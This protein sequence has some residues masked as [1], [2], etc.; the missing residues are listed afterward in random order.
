M[1]RPRDA[2]WAGAL[3]ILGEVRRTPG[4]T[5]AEAARRLGLGSGSAT[6]ITAR[7]RG[8]DLLDEI[9]AP[10]VG[11]GRP[12]T[13]LRPSPRGPLVAVVE[14]R[15]EDW[16]CAI[17]EIDGRP[18]TVAARRHG[19]GGGEQIV[20]PIAEVLSGLR[21]RYGRRL[22]A[23]SV[24][25]AGAV[26]HGRLVQAAP[27]EW[28]PTDLSGMVPDDAL[29]LLIGNDATLAGLAEARGGAGV[30]AG[31]VLHLTVEVGLGG[32]LVVGGVPVVGAGG[33]GG[34]Y[35]HMPFGDRS[36]RCLC[37]ARGC[38]DNDVD[39]RALARHLGAPPPEDPRAFA[40]EVLQRAA[41]ANAAGQGEGN[42]EADAVRRVA[43]ALASGIA[44]LV[45]AHDPDVVTLGGVAPLIRAAAEEEFDAAYLDGL[46]A[47]RRA[48]PIPLRAVA[49]GD[50]GALIGAAAAGLDLV[51]SESGLNDWAA[52]LEA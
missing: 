37:G 5:R 32:V 38:W 47:F 29:P 28:G 21:S 12:T 41:A 50:E 26:R 15:Y 22:R 17:S 44:G 42:A 39:G 9:P 10:V 40:Y 20:P 24:A 30:R 31:T 6:E 48:D 8:L 19:R 18:V 49:L 27:L 25:V 34:E 3:G 14:V 45:N 43:R 1:A 23:V 16:R 11:R 33:A 52:D 2:R 51:L 7:L 36:V 4:V 13:R 35:G 46:M